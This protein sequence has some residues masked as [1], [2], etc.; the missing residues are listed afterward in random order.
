MPNARVPKRITSLLKK[1]RLGKRVV[2]GAMAT[3]VLASQLFALAPAAKAQSFI[4]TPDSI[5]R[6]SNKFQQQLKEYYKNKGK[7]AAARFGQ[8]NSVE[9]ARKFF[10]ATS[11]NDHQN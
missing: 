5:V 4:G 7:K 6:N 9:S 10:G 3:L 2:L 1:L 11:Q 8:I